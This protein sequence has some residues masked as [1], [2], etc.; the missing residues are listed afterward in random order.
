VMTKAFERRHR[1]ITS[2]LENLLNASTAIRRS[3]DPSLLAP[4]V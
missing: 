2:N 3:A 1:R 4:S